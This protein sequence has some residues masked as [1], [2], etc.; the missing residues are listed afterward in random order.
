MLRLIADGKSNPEI[1]EELVIAPGTVERHVSN[2]LAKTGLRNR[3]ELT[4]YAV[5][6][7][8]TEG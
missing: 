7:A 2:L 3:A 8:L 5:E 6:H 4:R 1:A